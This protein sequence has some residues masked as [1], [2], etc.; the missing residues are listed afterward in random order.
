MVGDGG[1]HCALWLLICV[2]TLAQQRCV[3]HATCWQEWW[4]DCPV[5][6]CC[7]H[8]DPFSVTGE[9]GTQFCAEGW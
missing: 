6:V 9:C 5:A 1:V 7:P 8:N 4:G 2:S 3:R